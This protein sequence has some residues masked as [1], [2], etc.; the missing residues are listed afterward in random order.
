MQCVKYIK[1]KNPDIL[2]ALHRV[3]N[4]KNSSNSSEKD[5][6]TTPLKKK[7]KDSTA[8]P[9][10]SKKDTTAS[11]IDPSNTN[12]SVST[13][14]TKQGGSHDDNNHHQDL[15]QLQ[16]TY[17]LQGYKHPQSAMVLFLLRLIRN[18]A[19]GYWKINN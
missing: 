16:G 10:S 9:F 1:K 8:T 19:R 4:L 11:T 13:S 14:L 18:I 15:H 17:R 7:K 3:D 2:L 12:D 5:S 6:T